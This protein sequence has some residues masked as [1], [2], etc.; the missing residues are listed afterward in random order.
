MGATSM[1]FNAIASAVTTTES[2]TL[3]ATAAGVSRT[4]VLQLSETTSTPPEVKLSWDAPSATSDPIV[5]YNVYREAQGSSS[6]SMLTSSVDTQTSYTDAAVQ[7]GTT[8]DYV[9]KSVDSNGVESAPSNTIVV[10]VP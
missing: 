10:S 5:G 1:G 2:V 4:D 3:T 8:Y 7:S 6:Y 9:V